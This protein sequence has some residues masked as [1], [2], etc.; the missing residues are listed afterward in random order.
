MSFELRE[1]QKIALSRLRNGSIL[2]GSVGSGKSITS[3]AYFLTKV[4]GGSME[5]F[6]LTNP[7][8]LYIITTAK[9]RDER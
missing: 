6:E 7:T 4:C 2:N 9:K 5:T 1:Q 3:L 8:D